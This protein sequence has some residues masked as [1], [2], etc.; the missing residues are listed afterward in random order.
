MGDESRKTLRLVKA[1]AEEDDAAQGEGSGDRQTGPVTE[2]E[3][4]A[5]GAG[6]HPAP[7]DTGH[8]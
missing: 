2:G 7:R 5:T 3:V 8:Q 4:Q 6:N 1:L